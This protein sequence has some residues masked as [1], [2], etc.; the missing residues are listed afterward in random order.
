MLKSLM[1]VGFLFMCLPAALNTPLEVNNWA[2]VARS[3]EPVSAGVPLPIGE[4]YDLAKLRITDAS[5][6]PLPAQ[7]KALS[8][9]WREKN[10]GLTQNPSAKWVLCDFQPAYV[11]AI[12]KAQFFL[13]NDNSGSALVTALTIADNS[14]D[15]T[16][17]TGPLKFIVSK[18]HFNLFDGVWLDANGDGHFET[19]ERIVAS[20]SANGGL[21][22]AGDWAAQ[23]CVPG[24]VH[25]TSQNAPERVIIEEQGPMKV[26][27]RVEGRHYAPSN[28]VTKGLY[29]YSVFLTAYAGKPFVDVQYA[30]TN[31]YME[32]DKPE[33]GATPWTVYSWPFMEYKVALNLTLGGTQNYSFLGNTEVNGTLNTSPVQLLQGKGG[34]TITGAAGGTD[35]K[36]G[37]AISNGSLGIKVAMRDFAPNNPKGI[38]L[39][40]DKLTLDLFPASAT[41]YWLDPFSQKN[42]R[43]RIEFFSGADAAGSLLDLWKR[44]NAPLR[45]L[46]SREWYRNTQAWE[47]GLG[48]P[49]GPAASQYYRKSPSLWTRMAKGSSTDWITYGD[50]GRFDGG[51]AHWQYTSCFYKYLMTGDPSEF[52]LAESRAFYFCD[53][54]PVHTSYTRWQDLAFWASPEGRIVELPQYHSPEMLYQS[55][56]ATF[57]GFV[58][59]R[60]NFPLCDKMTQKQNLEYFLLT[61]D[62]YLKDDI[63]SEA[64]R[65]VAYINYRTYGNYGSWKGRG[66]AVDPERF[67]CLPNSS[68]RDM[69][70][71]AMTAGYAYEITGDDR[72]LYRAKV[73]NY[74]NG[75]TVRA[76]PMGLMGLPVPVSYGTYIDVSALVWDSTHPGMTPPAAYV[77][78]NFQIGIG[79]QAL[80]YFWEQTGDETIRDMIIKSAKSLEWWCSKDASGKHAGWVYVF[81]DYHYGGRPKGGNFF[82]AASEALGG[83]V[84]GYL[85]SGSKDLWK[86]AEA[87]I[88]S[89]NTFGLNEIM[90][91]MN[92]WQAMWKHDSLD[93]VPPAPVKDLR[94][95]LVPGTG[96]RLNWT[97]PG[98]DGSMGTARK[99]QIKYAKSPIVDMVGHWD[100]ISQKGWPD[101][102]GM[103]ALLP[104]TTLD[105]EAKAKNYTD[106][107][108][109][110]FWSI[111]NTVNE[112]AP[113]VA[114]SSE[115]FLI[116]GFQDSTPYH[117]ALVSYD[118][119]GNVSGLSN[120]AAVNVVGME[121]AASKTASRTELD[122]VPNP[123]NPATT[124]R[125][126]LPARLEGAPCLISVFDLTGRLIRNLVAGSSRPGARSIEWDGR[127]GNGEPLSS[128]LYL[129]RLT[130]GHETLMKTLSLI[131]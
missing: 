106:S 3:E 78:S 100:P 4:V 115:S 124:I 14:G 103:P 79:T 104:F 58:K 60:E 40:Q 66:M 53:M 2:D 33:T 71:P 118:R 105:L 13:K 109:V 74:G 51:G 75:N 24:T 91:S 55:K 70:R 30:V 65:A 9:W 122:N 72:Y 50:Y 21:V 27:I 90:Q 45:M 59:H 37:A 73:A 6:R 28:G 16:V 108:E 67:F 87:A 98:E 36:G 46:A 57:P 85:A 99:Y 110:S 97:A 77:T 120:P 121:N 88:P 113:R 127:D 117:F 68:G 102:R 76:C 15:I 123:F 10:M 29:G 95:T 101:L 114:G 7:F 119:E 81:G 93:T 5:G 32:G 82:S 125:Y 43:L 89:F 38:S 83:L 111:P 34:Y 129:C 42:H 86:V 49:T 107:F 52:E 19:N 64:L 47:R 80:Y 48:V 62:P 116:S 63:E 1:L 112:P 11:A 23:G 94:A 69:G 17:V 41:P 54:P 18:Q 12:N 128:G 26:V 22:T 8:K 39:A 84:F 96:V 31:T 92:L 35:A 44:T 56:Y 126:A 130:A 131:K 25:S 61:G 20:N